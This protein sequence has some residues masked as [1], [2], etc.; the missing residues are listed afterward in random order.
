M[1]RV[2]RSGAR[3]FRF[4]FKAPEE[5]TAPAFP[6]HPRYRSRAGQPNP[7]FLDPKTFI[8]QFLTPL[9]PY[10]AAVAV[11]IFEFPTA[12]ANVFEDNN[13]RLS[14]ALDRFFDKLPPTF[15][16]AVEVRSQRVL[17][18]GYFRTLRN[19]GIAH[20]FNSWTGMPSIAEQMADADAFTTTFTV[21]R[22]LTT[23]GR[24]Y[25]ETVS[26][27]APYRTVQEPNREV[28]DALCRLLVRSKQRGEPAFIYVN[29]RL[30]GFA[31][32]TIAAVI[33]AFH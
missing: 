28:R 2:V 21:S 16:Y 24:T 9:E 17:G 5:I 29:N 14:D 22:A 11:I 30:E 3:C 33:D 25:E 27:F 15:R 12:L 7:L 10:A 6:R 8:A 23:P 18:G 31:P 1:E 19:Q 26:L 13:G 20:V 32:G 4:A